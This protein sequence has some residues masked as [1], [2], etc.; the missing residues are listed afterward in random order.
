MVSGRVSNV[1]C[2]TSRLSYHDADN[3]ARDV[4]LDK[5]GVVVILDLANT[6]EATTA[7]LARLVVLRQ[8]LRKLGGELHLAHLHGRARDVYEINRMARLLPCQV[9]S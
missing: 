7:G 1:K 4:R 8:H 9:E 2:S 6:A 3:I 5:R